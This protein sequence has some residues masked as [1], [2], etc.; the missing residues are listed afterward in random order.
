MAGRLL[1]LG[2]GNAF[3]AGGMAHSA[4]L[5][6][7]ESGLTLL[8]CGATTLLQMKQRKVKL[9][10]LRTII[11]SHLHGDHFGGLPFLLLDRAFSDEA[12]Q[13]LCLIGPAQLKTQLFALMEVLYPA[14]ER[15]L[16]R[17]NLQFKTLGGERISTADF[18]VDSF[19]VKHSE[20]INAYAYR[21]DH[22]QF[23]VFYSGDLQWTDAVL[24]WSDG[25]DLKIIECNFLNNGKG[26]HV[27]F[28]AVKEHLDRLGKSETYFHHLD[29]ETRAYMLNSGLQCTEDG[30]TIWLS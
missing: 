26:G 10:N 14:S 23:K 8:E 13:P 3:H 27:S 16:E 15:H 17:L 4:F 30:L 29:Q 2:S 9:S 25:C 1:V 22:P 6:E 28:E 11:I 18:A 19:E 5:M 21:I 7:T 24:D 12:D 20:A